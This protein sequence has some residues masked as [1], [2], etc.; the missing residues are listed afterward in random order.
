MSLP[1]ATSPRLR[2]APR[3]RCQAA[4][5]GVGVAAF[6]ACFARKRG[7]TYGMPAAIVSTVG[8]ICAQ[9]QNIITHTSEFAANTL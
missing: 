2:S 1:G 3:A 9:S 8:S 6:C 7:I 4:G 5:A